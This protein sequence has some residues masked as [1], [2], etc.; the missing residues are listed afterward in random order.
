MAK[1]D[2]GM[3]WIRVR[4]WLLN[5]IFVPSLIFCIRKSGRIPVIFND[6]GILSDIHSLISLPSEDT[7][8]Q[9]VLFIKESGVN[10]IEARENWDNCRSLT[11]TI[12]TSCLESGRLIKLIELFNEGKRRDYWVKKQYEEY[13]QRKDAKEQWMRRMM[14]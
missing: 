4:L 12:P 9:F 2:D 8:Y 10:C 5:K 13:E 14:G 7:S 1:A 6:E 11:I 3:I